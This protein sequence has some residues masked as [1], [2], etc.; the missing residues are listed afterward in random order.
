MDKQ[1][2]DKILSAIKRGGKSEGFYWKRLDKNLEEYLNKY[3]I[4]LENCEFVPCIIDSD[5]EICKEGIIKRKGIYTP[6]WKDSFGYRKVSIKS[7][8]YFIH[9]LVFETFNNILLSDKQVIDHIDTNTDHN[10][11]DNLRVTD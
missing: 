3:N 1:R 4:T 2:R 10:C 11:L 6:G 5:V 7:K 9:R 8:P